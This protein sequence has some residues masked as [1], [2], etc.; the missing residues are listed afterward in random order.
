VI[1]PPAQLRVVA[2]ATPARVALVLL[3][4]G[5]SWWLVGAQT[6]D[7]LR[8]WLFG[9]VLRGG[10]AVGA[11]TALLSRQPYLQ[12]IGLVLLWIVPC[13]ALTLVLCVFFVGAPVT[14]GVPGGRETILWTLVTVALV[15][16]MVISFG[17]DPWI[18]R[19]R[20]R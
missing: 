4:L 20:R 6:G 14:G 17:I 8:P 7:P 16:A 2:R 10:A 15:E 9:R 1:E 19:S 12:R 3:L 5:L 11:L 13:A 18:R